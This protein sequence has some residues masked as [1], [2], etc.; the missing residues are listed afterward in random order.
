MSESLVGWLKQSNENVNCF[1]Y[2]NE[3]VM[4]KPD[5]N[6]GGEEMELVDPNPHKDNNGPANEET[7][8][9]DDKFQAMQDALER[10]L[11]HKLDHVR[12]FLILVE[13]VN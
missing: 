6:G 1:R 13:L 10:N 9:F 4:S 3:P 7:N 11:Y 5:G 12:Q 8:N 2:V